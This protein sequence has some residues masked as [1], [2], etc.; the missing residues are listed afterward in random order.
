MS[1][2]QQASLGSEAFVKE[3]LVMLAKEIPEM[4]AES[5]NLLKMKEMEL[6]SR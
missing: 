3:M 1:T 4:I 2:L 6:F 5:E